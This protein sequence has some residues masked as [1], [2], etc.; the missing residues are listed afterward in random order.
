VAAPR[1][2]ARTR[3][4]EGAT[5]AADLAKS[6]RASRRTSSGGRADHLRSRGWQER[7]SFM[8]AG[9][10]RVSVWTLAARP[11][12]AR[13]APRARC[14]LVCR[15]GSGDC[16]PFGRGRPR[17]DG[18]PGT[19]RTNRSTQSGLGL[20]VGQHADHDTVRIANEEATD[21]PRL[22]NW[23]VDDLVPGL[24]CFT[25]RRIDGSPQADVHAPI[26]QHGLRTECRRIASTAGGVCRCSCR[27]ANPLG[28]ARGTTSQ[29]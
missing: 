10:A 8:I 11:N 14:S 22:V 21:A 3:G 12:Q 7:R 16:V 18:R 13:E 5:S 15:S 19:Q 25:M 24:D 26:G 28:A 20:L 9:A 2:S 6:Q 23:T 29:L 1:A 4:N 17:R 27:W